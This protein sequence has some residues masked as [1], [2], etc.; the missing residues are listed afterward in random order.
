MSS[1]TKK[2]GLM[3]NTLNK[4]RLISEGIWMYPERLDLEEETIGNVAM[5]GYVVVLGNETFILTIPSS[6]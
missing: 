5:G 1:D 6:T 3:K 2:T 4:A